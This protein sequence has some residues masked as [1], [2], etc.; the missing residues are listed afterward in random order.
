MRAPVGACYSRTLFQAELPR[1]YSHFL[2]SVLLVFLGGELPS[3]PNPHA[4]VTPA[5]LQGFN[6]HPRIGEV[7]EGNGSPKSG[8]EITD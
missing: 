3:I 7:D 4:G 2:T 5:R 1:A 8:E 6:P